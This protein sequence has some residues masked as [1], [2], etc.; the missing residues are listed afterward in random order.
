MGVGVKSQEA[1][2]GEAVASLRARLEAKGLEDAAQIATDYVHDMIRNGWRPSAP[3][4]E[5][6]SSRGSH[7]TVTDEQR[8]AY[9]DQARELMRANRTEETA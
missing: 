1:R 2:V 6:H 3:A 5:H 7:V 4:V 9:A 8:K